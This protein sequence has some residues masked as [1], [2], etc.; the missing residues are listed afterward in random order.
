MYRE[1]VYLTTTGEERT[2]TLYD[3]SRQEIQER[4]D[5][6]ESEGKRIIKVLRPLTCKRCQGEG[7]TRTGDKFYRGK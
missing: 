4:I 6:L 5:I 2:F 1:I 7:F 3:A